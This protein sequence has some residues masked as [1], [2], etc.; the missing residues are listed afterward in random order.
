MWMVLRDGLLT[1]KQTRAFSTGIQYF[2]SIV[3][4]AGMPRAGRRI[5]PQARLSTCKI[6]ELRHKLRRFF[7]V[8]NGHLY[9]P[10]Q[11]RPF[12]GGIAAGSHSS[13]VTVEGLETLDWWKN[14]Y[15]VE[16]ASVLTADRLWQGAGGAGDSDGSSN[17]IVISPAR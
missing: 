7:M 2:S 17:V 16:N 13:H 15:R 5:H 10:P 1:K 8:R 3:C 6:E 12:K 4:G 11:S 9:C 14:K